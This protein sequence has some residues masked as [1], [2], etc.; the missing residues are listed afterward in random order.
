VGVGGSGVLCSDALGGTG[1]CEGSS[2]SWP[3]H[4]CCLQGYLR[5]IRE[6]SER[7]EQIGRAEPIPKI[8][9]RALE[10]TVQQEA[11]E[12]GAALRGRAG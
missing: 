1:G 6:L 11:R 12:V 5:V 3:S 2:G 9:Q 4:P 10:R 8:T 7:V